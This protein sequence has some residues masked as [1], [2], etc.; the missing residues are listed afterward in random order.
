MSAPGN[1]RQPREYT[2]SELS[3][4]LAHV[5]ALLEGR[6][7]ECS[8]LRLRAMLDSW[9]ADMRAEREDRER[10]AAEARRRAQGKPG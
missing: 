3:A 7:L 9:A 6:L 10:L 4:C 2:S 8:P 5:E 1:A